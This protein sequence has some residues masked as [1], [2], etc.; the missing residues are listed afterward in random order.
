MKEINDFIE[1]LHG[2]Q[3]DINFE[4][5]NN[6]ITVIENH[7]QYQLE[8]TLYYTSRRTNISPETREQPEHYDLEVTITSHDSIQVYNRSGL[9][10]ITETQENTLSE[11]ITKSL[12]HYGN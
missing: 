9:I 1:S 12:Y 3:F 2:T 5:D 6:F 8:F 11:I 7:G 4:E 10:E